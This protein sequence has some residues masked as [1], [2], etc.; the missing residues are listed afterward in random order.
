M[1]EILLCIDNT[2]FKITHYQILFTF[3]YQDTQ[4]AT[5]LMTMSII[6]DEM[7]PLFSV[8]PTRRCLGHSK[9]LQT[10]LCVQ[11]EAIPIE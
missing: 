10:H 1:T 8:G 7:L 9:T 5:E 2:A 11:Q 6:M 4:F 3:Y